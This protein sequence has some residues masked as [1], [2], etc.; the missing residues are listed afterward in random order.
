MKESVEFPDAVV[1]KPARK[2]RVDDNSVF[3][4]FFIFTFNKDIIPYIYI[5]VAINY[6]V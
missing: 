2:E 3:D 6:Y 1:M 4:I 5:F